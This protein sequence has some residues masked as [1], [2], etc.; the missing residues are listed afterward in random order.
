[1]PSTT[2]ATPYGYKT[3]ISAPFAPEAAASWF[4]DIKRVVGAPHPFG[5]L[6]DLRGQKPYS[7]ATNQII[8]DAMRYVRQQGMQ[9]SAVIVASAVTKMQIMRLAKETGMYDYERY[10]DASSD[11]QW[12]RKAVDW[13]ERGVDPDL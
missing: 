3:E 1:M 12:E 6:V 8:E 10:F 2:V 5:Q 9:R 7:E 11:P 4:E 13:I